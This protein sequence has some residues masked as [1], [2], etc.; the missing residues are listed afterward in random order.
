MF[1]SDGNVLYLDWC[2]GYTAQQSVHLKWGLLL[3]FKLLDCH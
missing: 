1:G 3:L 2:G